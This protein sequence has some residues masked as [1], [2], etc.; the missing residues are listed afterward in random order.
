MW[1]GR[2]L[3]PFSNSFSTTRVFLF[4]KLLTMFVQMMMVMDNCFDNAGFA[5]NV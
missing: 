3:L 1:K 4:P 5:D 2:G